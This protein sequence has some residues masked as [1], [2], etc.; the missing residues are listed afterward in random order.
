MD[1]PESDDL[2]ALA[3]ACRK[4]SEFLRHALEDFLL[5]L[6]EQEAVARYVVAYRQAP[7]GSDEVA[8][9]AS[10]ARAALAREPWE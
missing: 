9:T 3:A 1:R 6:K 2:G 10:A 7:E 4:V 8:E 5:G